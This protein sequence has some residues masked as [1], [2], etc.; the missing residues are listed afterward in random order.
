MPRV[1]C[2]NLLTGPSLPWRPVA[3]P[4]LLTWIPGIGPDGSCDLRTT[5]SSSS[6]IEEL[7]KRLADAGKDV[8][9]LWGGCCLWC[10]VE[11]ALC[12]GRHGR[13]AEDPADRSRPLGRAREAPATSSCADQ[14]FPEAPKLEAWQENE[15]ARLAKEKGWVQWKGEWVAPEDPPPAN[16]RKR[17]RAGPRDRPVDESHEDLA[18]KQAGWL[19]QDLEWIPPEEAENLGKGLYKC[20]DRWLSPEEADRYRAELR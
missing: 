9:K 10:E 6:S 16:L 5:V 4:L 20:G 12:E 1:G 3:D 14:W 18:H 2:A 15:A 13:P 11:P 8:A 17:P 7:D 19:R